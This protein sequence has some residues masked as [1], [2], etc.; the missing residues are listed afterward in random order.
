MRSSNRT[1]KTQVVRAEIELTVVNINEKQ[2]KVRYMPTSGAAM[3]SFF[4]HQG[5]TVPNQTPVTANITNRVMI[6]AT[7]LLS[8]PL[9]ICPPNK[10]LFIEGYPS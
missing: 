2:S 9:M 4:H 6:K 3:L 1:L 10:N 8:P 5:I 7:G